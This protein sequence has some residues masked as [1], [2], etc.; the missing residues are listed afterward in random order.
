LEIQIAKGI[1]T[2]STHAAGRVFDSFAALL[3]ISPNRITYEG[4]G[5][6]WM[7]ALARKHGALNKSNSLPVRT[8]ERDGLLV[9]EWKDVFGM[10]ANEPPKRERAGTLSSDFHRAMVD[11]AVSMARYGRERS[12]LQD[13]VLSGG[14]MM[15]RLFSQ[16]LATELET[17]GFRI[18][19]HGRVP[20]N[21]GG[22]S[23]GQ[24]ICAGRR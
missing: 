22:I 14:V 3:G 21:D 1:N 16:E 15:N 10:F 7:E 2:A 13:I 9:V 4:Q 12:G 11:A 5:A 8:Q 20:P 24:A 19:T 6:I 23:F 17:L 18:Y